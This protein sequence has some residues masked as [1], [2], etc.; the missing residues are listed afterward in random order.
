MHTT[1]NPKI[2]EHI[3]IIANACSYPIGLSACYYQSTTCLR[4]TIA[5]YARRQQTLGVAAEK[6]FRYS[7]TEDFN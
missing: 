2:S 3:L 6:D 5:G 1:V 4:T 7:Y